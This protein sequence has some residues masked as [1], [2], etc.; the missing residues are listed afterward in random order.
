MNIEIYFNFIISLMQ[1]ILFECNQF[2]KNNTIYKYIYF[3]D[4][5]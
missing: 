4:Y 2:W 1:I 3:N 5:I